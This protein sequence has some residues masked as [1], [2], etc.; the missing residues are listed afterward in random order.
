[1]LHSLI[2]PFAA[3]FAGRL[4]DSFGGPDVAALAGSLILVALIVGLICALLGVQLA[5][6]LFYC[7]CLK[8]ICTKVGYAPGPLVWFPVLNLFPQL[9]AAK[10]SGWFFLL[11]LVPVVSLGIAIVNWVKLC[12]A[13]GKPAVLGILYLLP[14]GRLGLACY[15]AFSD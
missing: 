6:H 4:R 12:E 9:G 3:G 2:I 7:Y 5:V 8:R 15:L 10:L 14:F 1:M 13:R 11:Y